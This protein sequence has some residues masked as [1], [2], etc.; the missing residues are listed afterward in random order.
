[1]VFEIRGQR[2][3][4]V[5]HIQ[6]FGVLLRTAHFQERYNSGV[7]PVLGYTKRRIPVRIPGVC[8][9]AGTSSIWTISA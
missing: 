5:L 4:Q 9:G 6:K 2:I 8:I 1:M 7:S 3:G